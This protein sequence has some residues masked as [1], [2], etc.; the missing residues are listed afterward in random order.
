[1]RDGREITRIE[2][3]SFFGEVSVLDGGARSA[4]V[5]AAGP[6]RCL[7]IPRDVI[8]EALAAQ[9]GAAWAMLEILANRLRRD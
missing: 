6:V 1:M 7:A 2:A 4:D 3:G 8:R 5:V 9:P